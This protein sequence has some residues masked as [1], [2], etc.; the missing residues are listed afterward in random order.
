MHALTH[1]TFDKSTPNEKVG[2][3]MES[4]FF[5]CSEQELYILSTNGVLE[6]SKVRI[7]DS[8]M[9]GFI[10]QVPVVPRIIF[11]ECGTFFKKAKDRNLIKELNFQDVLTELRGRALSDNEMIE[12]M[13]WWI[14]Y[15]SKGNH[16]N[17]SEFMR[18]ARFGG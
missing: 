14:S 4:Q 15:R 18:S 2:K 8:E 1:F 12:L 7:P 6:I 11:E 5:K 17:V 10:R 3:I 9:A 16:V 13:K